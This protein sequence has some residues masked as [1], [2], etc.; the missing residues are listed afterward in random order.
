MGWS[1]HGGRP[2]CGRG[3]GG[4]VQGLSMTLAGPGRDGRVRETFLARPRAGRRVLGHG[5]AMDKAA[6][7]LWER[8]RGVKGKPIPGLRCGGWTG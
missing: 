2:K 7:F 6:F 3:D 5:G 4:G 1:R 8:I